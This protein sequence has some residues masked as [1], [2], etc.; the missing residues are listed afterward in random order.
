MEKAYVSP[1]MLSG[2]R[3]YLLE[4]KTCP[5]DGRSEKD[6]MSST[7]FTYVVHLSIKLTIGTSARKVIIAVATFKELD[8]NTTQNPLE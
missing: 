7:L 1:R 2:T 4:R 5:E 8:Y 3:H 6:F